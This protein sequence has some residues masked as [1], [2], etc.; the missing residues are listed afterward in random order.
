M[1]ELNVGIKL[2]K[3]Y[4]TQKACL[5]GV[6][7]SGKSYSAGDIL[8]EFCK[9]D[10]P[11]VM[12]DVMGVHW[13][14]ATKYDIVVLGGRKGQQLDKS[15]GKEYAELVCK[16]IKQIVF[17][18]S[19]WNDFE[20]QEFMAQFLQEMFTL[21]SS[22]RIPRHIFVEEAEVF[23]PQQGYDSSKLSLLAGNKIMKR[24]RSVGLGMTLISQR[25]QDLNKKTLSQ[26]QC[27]FIMHMEGI[28]E[29]EVV[30]KMLRNDPNKTEHLNE[31]LSFQQGECLVY[32]PAWL[33][34]IK[35]FKFRERE[36]YHA[37]DTPS[38]DT[39]MIEPNISQRPISLPVLEE[40]LREKLEEPQLS[41]NGKI[42]VFLLVIGIGLAFLVSS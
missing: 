13:G 25:P 39:V 20:M 29:M 22:D 42:I 12:I 8:E 18:L 37:G 33:N 40:E 26:S 10:L 32:S 17:D 21:H 24:G 19:Q 1:T 14:V 23:F 2:P 7:G 6:T 31:I 34:E 16:E 38:L 5:L 3:D 27:T 36:C 11:F 35:T 9:Y 15:K 30:N 4:V 28:Q 41:G